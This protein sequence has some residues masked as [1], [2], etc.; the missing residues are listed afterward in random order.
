M[1]DTILFDLDGTLLP[2][3]EPTFL[4]AYFGGL[5][6]RFAPKGLN[7]DDLIGAIGA[8]IDRV[9]K[10]TG[11]ETNEKVFWKAFMSLLPQAT[12]WMDEFYRYYEEDFDQVRISS[13]VQPLAATIVREL[14]RKG[15]RTVLATNP[16][17]PRIAT[18]K[19]VR[20]AGLSPSDFE[21]IT[22]MENSTAAKP[23]PEYFLEVLRKCGSRPENCMMVGNDV[24]EDGAAESLGIPFY[25]VT[26]CIINDHHRPWKSL[27]CG[28]FVELASYLDSLPT[29][30]TEKERVIR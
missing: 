9:R 28:T 22:T 1:I 13:Q 30:G 8:G 27:R 29:V 11:P 19:R 6:K 26:D 21:L 2:L 4:R 24:W 16:L 25:L 3:D 7:P 10:N 15:Y 5:A 20:W 17:F 18:E 23:S 14:H 12:A